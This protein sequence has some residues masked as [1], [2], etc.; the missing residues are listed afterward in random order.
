MNSG[1]VYALAN[2]SPLETRFGFTSVL[3][4]GTQPELLQALAHDG[5]DALHVVGG[6]GAEDHG[7]TRVAVTR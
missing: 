1:R 3:P 6:A 2:S 7:R 4:V 5:P